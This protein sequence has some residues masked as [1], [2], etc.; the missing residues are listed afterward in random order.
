MTPF[1]WRAGP[2]GTGWFLSMGRTPVAF[3]Q[4]RRFDTWREAMDAA[5]AAVAHEPS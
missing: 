4:A 3:F 5:L 1:V 2:G